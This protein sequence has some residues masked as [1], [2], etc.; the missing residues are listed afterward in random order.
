M[1]E[2]ETNKI[3]SYFECDKCG[4]KW[5]DVK[6]DSKCTNCKEG[7]CLITEKNQ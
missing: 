2:E 3:L 7:E 6:K 4:R 1:I 5:L